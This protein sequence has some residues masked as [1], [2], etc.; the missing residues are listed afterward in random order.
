[1]KHILF[2]NATQ[3]EIVKELETKPVGSVLIRPS[4]GNDSTLV[5]S[6][7][8]NDRVIAMINI[9]EINK[10]SPLLIGRKLQIDRQS[11]GDLDELY[12]TYVEPLN[13]T[14]QSIT[15]FKYFREGDKQAIDKLLVETK[16]KDPKRTPYFVS[17]SEEHPGQYMLSFLPG[18]TPKHLYFVIAPGKLIIREKEFKDIDQLINYFKDH[19]EELL[20]PPVTRDKYHDRRSSRRYDDDDEY[21]PDYDR[22]HHHHHRHHHRHSRSYSRSRSRSRSHSRS[23]SR[24]DHYH[25]TGYGGGAVPPYQYMQVPMMPPQTFYSFQQQP[26]PH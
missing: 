25:D 6:W 8:M 5:M 13:E 19:S 22:H 10:V 26:P 4:G 1:L 17:I 2:R 24:H 3:P 18:N 23:R 16:K 11:F 15:R 21:D 12:G 7:K 20:K 9:Q 14:A